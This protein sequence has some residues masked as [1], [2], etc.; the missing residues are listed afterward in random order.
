[1]SGRKRVV[2][3]GIGAL[4][5]LGH[6]VNPFTASHIDE[7]LQILLDGAAK[8]G[9]TL[10]ERPFYD[11]ADAIEAAAR[12]RALTD[13]SVQIRIPGFWTSLWNW[14]LPEQPLPP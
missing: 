6:D 10:A 8:A 11:T 3:T 7:Y 9:L 1:M 13:P 5:P 14:L 4:S 2:I 12:A